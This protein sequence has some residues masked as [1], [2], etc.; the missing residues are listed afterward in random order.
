MQKFSS[1]EAHHFKKI[2]SLENAQEIQAQ[3]EKLL[4]GWQI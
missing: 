3:F 4:I 1:K 2:T